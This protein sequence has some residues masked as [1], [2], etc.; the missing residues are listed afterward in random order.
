MRRT[1]G[2][3]ALGLA[4][5]LLVLAAGAAWAQGLWYKEV[6]KDGRVYVFNTA[7]KY[8]AWLQSG[9][10][11]VAITMVGH[12]PKGE[13]VVAE[14]ETAIDLYNLKHDLPGYDRAEPPKA[15]APAAPPVPA[16]PAAPAAAE[17]APLQFRIGTTTIQPLGFLDFTGVYRNHN[18]GSGIGTNFGSIPYGDVYQ[19]HLTEFRFSAQNSRIGFRTDT[20]VK[21]LHLMGYFEGDFLG[22]VSG[23]GN[24]AVSSNSYTFRM[25]VFFADLKMGSFELAAGQLWSLITPG[26]TGISTLPGDLFYTQVIDVNYHA[27]LFWGRIPEVRFVY[28]PSEAVAVAVALDNPEQYV[29]GSAGGGVPTFPSALTNYAGAQLDNGTTGLATPNVAPDVIVKIAVDPSKRFHFEAGGVE[30]QF[31]V[32]NTTNGT[33]HSATGWGGFVNLNVGLV[34]GLR[35]VSSNFY[36]TG[37]GRY[38]FGQAPDMVAQADGSL[39]PVRSMSTVSGFEFVSGGTLLYAYYGGIAIDQYALLDANGKLIGYGYDGSPASHN[40][41]IQEGTVG[42]AQT[43]WKDAKYGALTLMGQ[44]SY[45]SRIPWYIAAGQPRDAHIG[46]FFV[47]VRYSLPGAAPAP[48]MKM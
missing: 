43:F 3:L 47:N 11:G 25:R 21:K 40:R 38:I 7:K 35:L 24:V 41:T 22:N 36:S 34:G 12:G 30:R 42:F 46:M 23:A 6:E 9:D 15:A 44:Y 29:G 5:A 17:P 14:N 20:D 19:N 10:M 37:G 1:F 33:R 48:A 26:R 32:Y 27:G 4:A 2:R 16:A 31:A 8:Q 28:H 18:A 45:V 39:I 13:T